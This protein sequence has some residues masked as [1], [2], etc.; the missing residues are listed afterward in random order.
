VLSLRTGLVC[1]MGLLTSACSANL[2]QLYT[3]IPATVPAGRYQYQFAYDTDFGTQSKIGYTSL[4]GGLSG[5]SEVRAG[6][7]RLWNLTGGTPA[8]SCSHPRPP[9]PKG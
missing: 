3:G 2:D 6:Y 4:T 5:N 1:W 9:K 8:V 7:G